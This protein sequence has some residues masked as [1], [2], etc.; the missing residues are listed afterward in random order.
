MRGRIRRRVQS[1]RDLTPAEKARM[2]ALCQAP[3]LAQVALAEMSRETSGAHRDL[4]QDL[5]RLAPSP[6]LPEAAA[7]LAFAAWLHGDGALAWCA[8]DRV[9]ADP[10]APPLAEFVAAALQNAVSPSTWR[11]IDADLLPVFGGTG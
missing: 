1:G 4:W 10:K 2:L 9:P 5:V 3:L 7:L 11:P 8:L 6:L